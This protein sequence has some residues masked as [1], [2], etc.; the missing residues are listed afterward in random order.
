M[1]AVRCNQQGNVAAAG[2]LVE[3]RPEDDGTSAPPSQVAD[4]LTDGSAFSFGQPHDEESL[5]APRVSLNGGLRPGRL[6]LRHI[7][8]PLSERPD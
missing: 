1:W 2:Q 4:D 5:V 3:A 6:N 7:F 8:V